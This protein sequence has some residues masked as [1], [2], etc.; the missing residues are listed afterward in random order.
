M[1][2]MLLLVIACCLLVTGMPLLA[3]TQKKKPEPAP[4]LSITRSTQDPTLLT[5]LN[6]EYLLF[7]SAP[8]EFGNYQGWL[9]VYTLNG[10]Q[11]DEQMISIAKIANALTKD[12]LA[13]EDTDDYI[14]FDTRNPNDI[15][16]STTEKNDEGQH[17]YI[18]SRL[19]QVQNDVFLLMVFM[20]EE[21]ANTPQ[22]QKTFFHAV[23]NTPLSV[24]T[25]HFVETA[26]RF[27]SDCRIN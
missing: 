19:V 2:K 10:E 14:T 8:E 1:K 25:E 12:M 11:S 23:R 27:G 5:L 22:V 16:V 4:A 13:D 17:T 3:A 9:N 26:C 21:K 7:K 24:I 18:V 15:L 6:N 20:P